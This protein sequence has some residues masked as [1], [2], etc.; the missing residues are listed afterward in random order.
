MIDK[1]KQKTLCFCGGFW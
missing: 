1:Q